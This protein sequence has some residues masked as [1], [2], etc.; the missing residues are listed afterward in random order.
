MSTLPKAFCRFNIIPI[1]I[2]M[3][4]FTKSFKNPKLQV[5]PQKTWN[6]LSNIE[7]EQ[8]WSHHIFWFQNILRTYSNCNSIVLAWKQT[9]RP[10]EQN[11]EPRNKP[12][13]TLSTDLWQGYTIGKWESLQQMM[14]ENWIS[15]C[16]II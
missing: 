3:V 4:L 7:K 1:K 14:L 5:E 16:K 15:T 12:M 6:S 9:S 8:S 13:V 10:M 2:L 11:R